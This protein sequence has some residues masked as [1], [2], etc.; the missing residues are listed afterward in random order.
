MR[1]KLTL[2]MALSMTFAL[3]SV[4]FANEILG[5]YYWIPG[6]ILSISVLVA[7]LST[8]LKRIFSDPLHQIMQNVK[9]VLQEQDYST[10]V[11]KGCNDEFSEL[12][13]TLNEML[14]EIHKRDTQLAS[15][16]HRLEQ[17]VEQ[18]TAELSHKNLQLEE[19]IVQAVEAQ[20]AA[21]AASRAKSDFLATMSHEIRTPMNGVL[22]M[23]EL[24]LDTSLNE[25][26]HRFAQT[27]Q[28][29]G[30]AL[31]TIINDILD[32]SKIEAGKLELEIHGFN[33]RDLMDEIAELLAGRAYAKGLDLVPVLP[34]DLPVR[35]LGDSNRLRQVL[36]NL[37]GNAIKFTTV[38][39]VVLSVNV[40]DEADDQIRFRFQVS[41]TGIGI[42]PELQAQIF[43]AFAQADGSTTRQY[44]GTGLG[45]TISRRLV[46]LMDGEMGVESEVG[47]GASFW[48]ELSMQPQQQTDAID[49][50]S[51]DGL[52]G[53]RVLIV[54]DNGTNRDILRHQVV[55][56][57]MNNSTA[58]SGAQ[59]LEMLYEAVVAGRPYD[60]VLL[61][62]NMPEMD[63]VEL[64]HRIVSNPGIPKAYLI[65]LSSAGVDGESALVSD[66]GVDRYLLKP[67]RQS[68][69]HDCLL[70]ILGRSVDVAAVQSTSS[71]VP[72]G[73]TLNAH[74]LLAEDNPVNQ[75]VAVTMLELLGCQVEVAGN[76]REVLE[77]MA[78]WTFDLVLM[79]CHMPEMDG[80]A[81]ATEIRLREQQD[82]GARSIPIIALTANVQKG[83]QE[84]CRIAGMDDYLSK[85]FT[86]EQ[87]LEHLRRWVDAR[88]LS[89]DSPA[90]FESAGSSWREETRCILK[91]E[92]LDRIRVL[93]RP[94]RPDILRKAIGLYMDSAP[95]L[96]QTLR[97]SIEQGDGEALRA[98]AHSLKSSSANLGAERL[99][100]L[101]EEL[102]GMGTTGCMDAGAALLDR[103]DS[104]YQAAHTALLD[105]MRGIPAA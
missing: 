66:A 52:F 100:A 32:F 105:E 74:V 62:R 93:Q 22:G 97:E 76:G 24:L 86:R 41:D 88:A 25:Q 92:M 71:V 6:L 103:V 28:R 94:G 43:D 70:E 72:E 91:Q 78:K 104:E 23:T 95:G 56:W 61:D 34:L 75:E 15:Y 69:L 85:P 47:K 16:R 90:L 36:V 33:L 77:A 37:L 38:G 9:L 40:L 44:G 81:A 31:L 42:A 98:A 49:V 30:D 5:N 63:G 96:M 84:R 11:K 79:D 1:K 54:D 14:H 50:P 58:E 10:G 27:I 4:T 48:F 102:E 99:A 39:E 83:V 2:I 7:L 82:A 45:L 13:D 8:G 55:A 3:L 101:C 67:V 89:P 73:A 57:G 51:R 80:F 46:E 35:V 20:Y 21:E 87:L 29:S 59:A 17:Q 53:K 60:V 18:R 12:V 26:Q 68:V 19:T 65:M 64:A